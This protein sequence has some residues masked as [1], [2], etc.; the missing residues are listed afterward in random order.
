MNHSRPGSGSVGTLARSAKAACAALA[1]STGA[2]RNAALA[3]IAAALETDAP[4]IL[5]A[6]ARDQEAAEVA[7]RNGELTEGMLSRLRLDHGRLQTMISQVLAVAAL[8]DPLGR[9]LLRST[10]DEGLLLERVSCPIGLI[11]AIF[12]ARPDAVT[13]TVALALKSGNAVLLKPGREIVHTAEALARSIHGVLDGSDGIGPQCVAVVEGR[14]S[15]DAM[16]ALEG[17]VDLVVPRGSNAMVRS[18]RERTRIAVL[19]HADGI[20]H[21]FVDAQAE[22]G[23]AVRI[24]VDSKVQ[25]PA[26]CNAAEVI[27]V[28]ARAAERVID[29]IVAALAERGVDVRGC[30]RTRAIAAGRAIIPAS[31][32]DFVTEFG[33]L[34]V[35]IRIVDG[36]KEAVTHINEHGSH[37]TDSMVTDDAAAAEYFLAH[38]DS[39]GV[40]HNVST[41]YADGYR[42]GLGAEIGISTGKL[43]ARGPVGLEGLTTY[44]YLLRGAGHT[45]GGGSGH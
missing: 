34:V 20:C 27:L 23:M 43:H 35:A 24:V 42:Y 33:G 16:L 40:F 30:E 7:C 29:P 45:V 5:A 3:R 1:N 41:R 8:D 6:N 37:H 21:V 2:A 9:I 11:A 13:Q 25:Y 32:N 28:D 26:A 36:V 19:G 4:A 17:V 38:V 10:L 14:D 12:E 44:K 22:T 15:V 18:I 31:E 39:A